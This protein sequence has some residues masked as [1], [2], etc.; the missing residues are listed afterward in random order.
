MGRNYV[1]IVKSS[2]IQNMIN[3]DQFFTLECSADVNLSNISVSLLIHPIRCI[4]WSK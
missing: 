2:V 1:A 4:T 3:K